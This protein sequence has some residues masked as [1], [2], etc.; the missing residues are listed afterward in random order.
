LN[1]GSK[2]VP[3][4]DCNDVDL[5]ALL[6]EYQQLVNAGDQL[7][8]DHLTCLNRLHHLNKTKNI[9]ILGLSKCFDRDR[10]GVYPRR[11]LINGLG[12]RINLTTRRKRLT[13]ATI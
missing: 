7:A 11:D 10:L 13:S 6:K 5:D 8:Q 9:K 2:I 4:S 1:L 3:N 12:V